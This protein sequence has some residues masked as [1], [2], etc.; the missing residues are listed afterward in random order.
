MHRSH[1]SAQE[2]AVRSRLAQLVHVEPVLR[3]TLN[4][5]EVTC[6][7]PGCRCARGEKHLT[8]YAVSSQEGKPRQLFVPRDLEECVRQWVENYHKVRDLLE[9]VSE[10][11]WE[12]IKARK[13]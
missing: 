3:A 4:V 10:L 11:S 1:M 13:P 9:Q 7:K 5:R 12:R 6:G 2:R 8:L